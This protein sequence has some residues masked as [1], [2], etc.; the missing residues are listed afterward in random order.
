MLNSPNLRLGAWLLF[1]GLMLVGGYW[2]SYIADWQLGMIRAG[3]LALALVFVVCLLDELGRG[4]ETARAPKSRGFS[5]ARLIDSACHFV[6]LF[7]FA[8][9]G[10][11]ELTVSPLGA[12][13]NRAAN[14]LE[15][16]PASAAILQTDDGTYRPVSLLDIYTASEHEK[17]ARVEVSG[18]LYRT[19]GHEVNWLD[20]GVDQ[21]G[22]EA[23]LYRYLITC[24]VADALPLSIVLK[25]DNLVAPGSSAGDWVRIRGRLGALDPQ[26]LVLALEVDSLESIE[27][28]AQPYL[29]QIDPEALAHE[30]LAGEGSPPQAEGLSQEDQQLLEQT[31]DELGDDPLKDYNWPKSTDQ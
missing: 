9:V 5:W 3:V 29:A 30:A 24:C 20:P 17:G 1:M 14:S 7:I 8:S 28:P 12:A 23:L 15:R 11:T 2:R 27:R 26:G 31:P 21:A 6:P 10:V 19:E 4:R 13:S 16:A 18:R 22:V 25:G